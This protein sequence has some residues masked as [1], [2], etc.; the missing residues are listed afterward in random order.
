[1]AGRNASL[2]SPIRVL[3]SYVFSLRRNKTKIVCYR[4][5]AKAPAPYLNHQMNAQHRESL[6][7]KSEIL[8][9]KIGS[10]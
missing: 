2:G 7:H 4:D 10:G 3:T 8:A 5:S 1:M 6:S 9:R